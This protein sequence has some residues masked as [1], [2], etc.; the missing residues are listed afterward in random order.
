MGAVVK[1]TMPFYLC[2]IAAL[3]LITFIPDISLFIP[4]MF[5][6]IPQCTRPGSADPEKQK[7]KYGAGGLPSAPLLVKGE[8][9]HELTEKKQR[10]V[11]HDEVLPQ[12]GGAGVTRRILAYN[13][14]LMCVE[15]TF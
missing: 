10:W 3:L 8:T 12:S 15:N 13:D 1:A 4:K 6:Y 5:G 14:G 9:D 7:L 2:M 11:P